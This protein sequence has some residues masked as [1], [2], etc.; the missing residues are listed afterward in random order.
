MAE[1]KYGILMCKNCGCMTHTKRG[2]IYM[3]GKCDKDRR[4]KAKEDRI[5]NGLCCICGK[6]DFF[7]DKTICGRC[8][9]KWKRKIIQKER[10]D[11]I[12][13]IS[14]IYTSIGLWFLSDGII[15]DKERLERIFKSYIQLIKKRKYSRSK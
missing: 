14:E 11:D 9:Q 7:S 10:I 2:T 8:I 1:N 5:K 15:V 12:R 6:P 4:R 13:I 3:C